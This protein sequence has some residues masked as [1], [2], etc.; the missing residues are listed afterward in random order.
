ML[1]SGQTRLAMYDLIFNRPICDYPTNGHLRVAIL[2]EGSVCCEAFKAC[3]S[4]GQAALPLHITVAGKDAVAF[5]NKMLDQAGDY[6]DLERF[7]EEEGYARFFFRDMD[8]SVTDAEKCVRELQLESFGYIILATGN[9]RVTK[10]LASAIAKRAHTK[11]L[12]AVDT[13]EFTCE[14]TE[15]NVEV[16]PYGLETNYTELTRLAKNI[17]FAYA[18]S[19]KGQRA[20]REVEDAKFERSQAREFFAEDAAFVGGNYDADSSFACAAHI[21]A[22]L[23]LCKQLSGSDRPAE[24]I[25]SESIIKKNDTYNRLLEL[26]HRR[27]VAYMAIRGFRAPTANEEQTLL[28]QYVDGRFNEHRDKKN[29]IHICMCTSEKNGITLGQD[30]LQWEKDPDSFASKLDQAS[31][32]AHRLAAQASN[33]VIQNQEQLFSKLNPNDHYHN[34]FRTAVEKLLNNDCNAETLYESAKA[35]I[36][37]NRPDAESIVEEMEKQI[38]VVKCRNRRTDFVS[39]DAQLI[40]FLP[41]CLWYRKKYQ[42]VITL[43][44]KIP[45]RDV[46]IPT[47]FCAE[48]ALFLG[49]E[50]ENDVT[51]QSRIRT[52]FEKRGNNT[53]AVPDEDIFKYKD[54]DI[55]SITDILA[56]LEQFKQVLSRGDAILNFVGG[57]DNKIALAVGMFLQA[58]NAVAMYYDPKQGVIVVSGDPYIAAGLDNKSFS[59]SEIIELIG[60]SIKN[61]LNRFSCESDREKLT[62]IFK[63]FCRK[64]RH[65]EKDKSVDFNTWVLMNSFFQQ[66]AKAIPKKIYTDQKFDI[67]K[68]GKTVQHYCKTIDSNVFDLSGM[69]AWL[70]RLQEYKVIANYA[71]VT[72]VQGVEINF[73]YCEKEIVQVIEETRARTRLK[74]T[75][76]HGIKTL[77][78]RQDDLVLTT[79]KEHI[80]IRKDKAAYMDA[81]ARA[82]FIGG[83]SKRCVETKAVVKK[84]SYCCNDCKEHEK[85]ENH[86]ICKRATE[87][88]E[89]KYYYSF[90]F[91]DEYIHWLLQQQGI[92]FEEIIYHHARKFGQFDDVQTG[93]QIAWKKDA[94]NY[95]DLLS[96]KLES[97]QQR[98]GLC[99]YYIFKQATIE[100]KAALK[101]E[102]N[103]GTDNEIDVIAVQGMT[104]IFMS[105]KTN[106]STENGWIYEIK[107]VADHFGAI[108]AM[109]VAQDCDKIS[110][111]A[112]AV[113]AAQMNVSLLGL[114][115]MWDQDRLQE[116]F[117]SISQGVLV[118][119]RVLKQKELT[120]DE[121]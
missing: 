63:E 43:T 44:S 90:A 112:F 93:V 115:T 9:K 29:R 60:G 92:P 55:N 119:P 83:L 62:D 81:L 106:K 3:F 2:G 117:A 27:W 85:C 59:V 97:V 108:P 16:Y 68:C 47:L 36:L 37:A 88:K 76:E 67:E 10:A 31:V 75:Q 48:K 102:E 30:D 11:C 73:D 53:N 41:F 56:S 23:S 24:S 69:G 34:D 4:L 1:K 74:F 54:C 80:V 35:T 98:Y 12:I 107:S 5:G 105:A 96:E 65:Y 6:P 38:K 18:T 77:L 109:I 40:N 61:P 8:F 51:Y 91:R 57:Q 15:P 116:A 14:I 100:A 28:Y 114:E 46:V 20:S 45:V 19:G 78:M 50:I 121:L 120:K 71:Y 25:L 94:R 58:N 99:G 79:D 7:A 113:R 103:T 22:K 49:P 21:P 89:T 110:N 82:G 17:N 86:H 39:I 13:P 104:P 72:T 26:E 70:E 42:T 95:N 33:A 66:Q 52:Y 32:R 111:S 64:Q 84:C 87:K 118:K 101:W